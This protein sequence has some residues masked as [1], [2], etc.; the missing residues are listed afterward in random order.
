V[1]E[2]ASAATT[3][4]HVVA[5]ILRDAAG[6]VLIAQRPAGKPLAGRWEFPGGKVA[7]GE[8]AVAAL[9]RELSEELGIAMHAAEPLMRY[10]VS[11]PERVIS[12]DVWTVSAWS[13]VP[14]GLDGQAFEWVPPAELSRHDIL[15]ADAPIVAALTPSPA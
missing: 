10:D 14:Q 15:E 1:S 8:S 2:A 13:G 11:Y 3:A 4:I 7:A 6:R 12:L 9:A 5:G